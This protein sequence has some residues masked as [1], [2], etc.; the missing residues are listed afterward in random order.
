ML[1]LRAALGLVIAYFAV[2][3]LYFGL[4]PTVDAHTDIVLICRVSGLDFLPCQ[5]E[6]RSI[7]AW[8]LAAALAVAVVAEALQAS[9]GK[10]ASVGSGLGGAMERAA[11]QVVILAF[12]SAIAVVL[13]MHNLARAGDLPLTEARIAPGESR[14]VSLENLCWPLL[15]QLFV[16]E[17]QPSWKATFGG[18]LLAIAA[19][20]PFRAV[21]FAILFFGA[22]VPL[23][24]RAWRQHVARRERTWT[25]GALATVVALSAGAIAY[26]TQMR[27]QKAVGG[28]DVATR[29]SA[30]VDGLISRSLTPFFQAN[31]VAMVASRPSQRVP[32]F[33]DTMA[34]KFRRGDRTN[35]NQQIFNRLYPGEGEATSLLYGE[36]AANSSLWPVWWSFAAPCLLLLAYIALRRTIDMPVLF[37]VALWRSTMGGLFDILPALILQIGFCLMLAA[38]AR[39][40]PTAWKR[41]PS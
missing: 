10:P 12:L 5:S 23:A 19:L 35:L 17:R 34:A 15:L 22:V 4:H 40:L 33:V 39:G 32:D 11:P 27:E 29:S 25:F 3:T 37:A 28:E 1:F 9:T 2:A 7:A 21:L 41:V 6:A 8:L 24:A 38:A 31:L 16:W 30:M 36:A 20:S 18:L 14:F 26:E 13:V